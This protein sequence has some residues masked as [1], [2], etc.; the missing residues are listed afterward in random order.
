MRNVSD[1]IMRRTEQVGGA[2]APK[3]VSKP[4][5]NYGKTI[6]NP[7]LSENAA[8]LYDEL[9]EKYSDMD[10]TLVSRDMIG[11][12]KQMAAGMGNPNKMVVLIDEDK[13]EKMA[14]DP[15]YR[16]EIEHVIMSARN[17]MPQLTQM[18]QKNSAIS[19]VGMQVGKDNRAEFFAVVDKSFKDLNE[20]IAE[21]RAQKKADKKAAEK[22]EA[23]EEVREKLDERLAQK[24]D[25]R[26]E[27]IKANSIEELMQKIDDYMFLYKSDTVMTEQ[28]MGIGQ[29]I[30]FKG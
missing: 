1:Q 18:M 7:S 2:Q 4:N 23:K 26:Y 30:D 22:K 8:K 12:A 14:A 28:E 25:E 17:K 29:H 6:G 11:V 3:E 9:K 13:L 5:K 16:Q 19:Q 24:S 20:R 21:K 27:V 10:F 15:K